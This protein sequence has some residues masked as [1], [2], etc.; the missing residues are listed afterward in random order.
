MPVLSIDTLTTLAADALTS[1][2]ASR[3]AALAA[4]RA[5]TAADAQGLASHGVS[6]VPQYAAFLRNGRSNGQASPR[7]VQSKGG[8][9]LIDAQCGMAYEACA[10][11]VEQAIER[12]R[13]FGIACVGVTNSN[14]FGAAAGHLG[15]IGKA[16]L[17]GMAF[18]NSPAAMPAWGG[19]TPLFGTNPIA[20]IF[21]RH[22]AQALL[23]D[24]ALSEAARG[25]IMVAAKEGKPIP[26]GWA[27]D[28]DG[29]PTTDAKAA[30]AG[31]MLP[32][33]GVKGAMLAL[34]VELLACALT[35]AA[36]GF[37]ADSFFVE[38]GNQPRLGQLF[39]AIDPGAM[40]GADMYFSR[41]EKLI[42]L[43]LQDEGVR[44]PGDRRHALLEKA[45]R[46]GITIPDALHQQIAALAGHP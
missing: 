43:M 18:G 11:A 6:R 5:L 38:A 7:V 42:E 25:K 24:L 27:V 29:K 21:P 14:H 36:F 9:C 30:L 46:E 41:T 37:E 2:G 15:P 33:G 22:D 45:E 39:L 16:G 40:A 20:A 31:S 3:S 1:A 17:V 32:T 8:A 28:K 23:I 44:L 4:A 13:E 12:A 10:M 34:V 19:K 26:L 35:G